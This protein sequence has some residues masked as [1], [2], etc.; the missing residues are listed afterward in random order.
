MMKDVV[1]GWGGGGV[2][3]HPPHFVSLGEREKKKNLRNRPLCD[4]HLHSA[5]DEKAHVPE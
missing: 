5:A 1:I 2:D 3:G 4:Y